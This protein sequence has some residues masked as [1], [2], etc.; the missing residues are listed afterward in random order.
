MERAGVLEVGVDEQARLGMDGG[1]SEERCVT[2]PSL[3]E[4]AIDRVD[5]VRVITQQKPNSPPLYAV[6]N[7]PMRGRLSGTFGVTTGY[8]RDGVEAVHDALRKAVM[9]VGWG[10]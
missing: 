1:V 10:K 9:M 6:C 5:G 4:Q 7:F 3:F 8:G 2:T